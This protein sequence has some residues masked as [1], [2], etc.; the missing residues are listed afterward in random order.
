MNPSLF[1]ILIA[2]TGIFTLLFFIGKLKITNKLLLLFLG[3]CLF[4]IVIVLKGRAAVVGLFVSLFL[5]VAAEGKIKKVTQSIIIILALCLPVFFFK[6]NSSAG[7]WLVYKVTFSQSTPANWLYGLGAGKFKKHYNNWQSNYFSTRNINSSEA[8]LAGDTLY[9]FNDYLQC[10]LEWGM[11]NC[12][13]LAVLLLVLHRL[14]PKNKTAQQHTALQISARYALLVLAI[15]ALFS[16]P[17]QEPLIQVLAVLLLYISYRC[18]YHLPFRWL[19]DFPVIAIVCTLILMNAYK[20]TTM[21]EKAWHLQQ[22]GQI[23]EALALY[24]QLSNKNRHNYISRYRY[25]RLLFLTRKTR[26][27]EWQLD[28]LLQSHTDHHA[29]LLLAQVLEATGQT[30]AAEKEYLRAVHMVPALMYTRYRLAL[31][32]HAHGHAT[33]FK[34]WA[35]SVRYMPVKIPSAQTRQMQ[36]VVSRLRI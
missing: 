27:A 10:I 32:Y 31:F 25:A 29:V 15:A 9:L 14:L 7:R 5:F 16:Y 36:H 13:L 30:T 4:F 19:C 1:A 28:T 23:P 17:L 11:I 22:G 24:Q 26:E 6:T 20:G 8:L 12:T 18:A 33:K 2:V 3:V 35:Q 21:K 34:H